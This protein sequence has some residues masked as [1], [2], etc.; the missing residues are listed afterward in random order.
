[1]QQV[2]CSK[3]QTDARGEEKTSINISSLTQYPKL[4]DV[5]TAIKVEDSDI[6]NGRET[7]LQSDFPAPKVK[8]E[9]SEDIVDDLDHIVLKERQRMLL[10]RYFMLIVD[11]FLWVGA[12]KH[13]FLSIL[14][15]YKLEENLNTHKY[16]P[17][18][19]ISNC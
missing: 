6:D 4:C 8:Q 19:C 17:K 13:T 14:Y 9:I 18:L 12:I 7:S 11:I 10:A 5:P 3:V 15:S 1:M 16:P 2:T